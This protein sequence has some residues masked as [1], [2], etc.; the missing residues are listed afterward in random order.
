MN[1]IQPRLTKWYILAPSI[2]FLALLTFVLNKAILNMFR[3]WPPLNISDEVDLTTTFV[4]AKELEQ[5]VQKWQTG[6]FLESY[7][8]TYKFNDA[9]EA[10]PILTGQVYFR[11]A[12]WRHDWLGKWLSRFSANHVIVSFKFDT[13]QRKIVDFS[14][15][16][17]EPFGFDVPLN[18]V[19]WPASELE[20]L[21]I[22]DQHGGEQFRETFKVELAHTT[23]TVNRPGREWAVSYNALPQYFECVINL[24]SGVVLVKSEQ[25]GWRN[26][27]NLFEDNLR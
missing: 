2:I 18:I 7:N 13:N 10:S 8:A 9:G 17:G 21:Q 25:S 19:N 20:L 3:P 11:F 22:C 24:D 14:Y 5:Q 23:A 6:L 4:L 26:A 16:Q 12:G 27:G 15:S 1:Y